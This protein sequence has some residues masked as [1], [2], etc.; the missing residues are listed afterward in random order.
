MNLLQTFEICDNTLELG[1]SNSSRQLNDDHGFGLTVFNL[2]YSQ[3]VHFLDDD[4]GFLNMKK[5]TVIKGKSGS[6]YRVFCNLGKGT[7]GQAFVCRGLDTGDFF[8][9]K[10]IRSKP[11]YVIQGENELRMLSWINDVD[12]ND[13]FHLIR[14]SDYLFIHNHHFYLSPLYS[15]TL[16]QLMQMNA[17]G[18]PFSLVHHIA[19]SV[20][21]HTLSSYLASP[22]AFLSSSQWGDSY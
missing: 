1:D 5:G 19:V 10:I 21:I 17:Q 14:L 22:I 3:D 7:F 9:V 4:D 13:N 11:E 16:F 6:L 20:G 18:L 8:A 2:M 12:A 15:F